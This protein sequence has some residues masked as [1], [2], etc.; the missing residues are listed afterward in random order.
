[1]GYLGISWPIS[2][3]LTRRR[4][5]WKFRQKLKSAKITWNRNFP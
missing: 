2:S 4:N 1:L 3:F 5:F